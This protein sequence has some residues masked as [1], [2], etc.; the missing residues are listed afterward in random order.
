MGGFFL[1]V[2]GV[3]GVVGTGGILVYASQIIF[4]KYF[5]CSRGLLLYSASIVFIK[6]WREN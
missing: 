2:G 4:K 3:Y 1:V 5:S 6:A